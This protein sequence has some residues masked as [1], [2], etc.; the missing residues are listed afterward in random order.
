MTK[1]RS[2]PGG[3]IPVLLAIAVAF[4]GHAVHAQHDDEFDGSIAGLDAKFVDVNGTRTRYYEVGDGEPMLLI[5]GSSFRGTASANT[6][7][8]V[9]P[10][11][12]ESIASTPT[13]P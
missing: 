1:K 11:L 12:G 7:T 9:I 6:W 10:L 4:S 5:R 8:P 13:T 3:L 2:G